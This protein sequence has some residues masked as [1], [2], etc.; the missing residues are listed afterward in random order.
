LRPDLQSEEGIVKFIVELQEVNRA[1]MADIG[2]PLSLVIFGTFAATFDVRNEDK[3]SEVSA[4][5]RVMQRVATT[6]GVVVLTT[7][8]FGKD[9]D[10]GARGSSAFEANSDFVMTIPSKGKLHLL[11][12]RDAIDGIMLG[13]FGL[14]VVRL[15]VRPNGKIDT[16]R[17]VVAVPTSVG[18]FNSAEAPKTTQSRN[19]RNLASEVFMESLKKVLETEKHQV[20]SCRLV[21]SEFDLRWDRGVSTNRQAFNRA[22]RAN[23]TRITIIGKSSTKALGLQTAQPAA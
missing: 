6:L 10:R 9:K 8:H 5:T 23:S 21:R 17:Y 20:V 2:V 13:T 22:L 11:K 16:S 1:F 15:R 14:P 4:V 18:E 7:H 19:H 12:C 3:A